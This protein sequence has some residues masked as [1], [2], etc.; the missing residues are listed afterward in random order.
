MSFEVVTEAFEP[1]ENTSTVSEQNT[2]KPEPNKNAKPGAPT[3]FA[4]MELGKWLQRSVTEA[5]YETPTPIQ[6]KTI[7]TIL[8]GLDLIGCAQTGTGKTAAF[9]LPMLERLVASLPPKEDR[10]EPRKEKPTGKFDKR[11]RRN[12]K[13]SAQRGDNRP[14]RAL[15]LA[16]TR[17]L[18]AQIG[19]SLSKYGRYTP[20]RHTVVYGGVSQYHQVKAIR[21]G[22]DTIVA[23]PGRLIDLMQQGHIKLGK[24]E[25]LVFDE[26]DQ[27]LDMGFLPDLKRIIAAVPKVRQTLMFSATMPKEIRDLAQQW[28]INPVEIQ[29]ATIAKPAEK[30]DQSVFHIASKQKPDLLAHYLSET[31]RSRTLVFSR[32]KHGADK[33][34][35]SLNNKGL[36]AAAIHGNKSQAAR[37]RVLDQFKSKKPPILVATDI[38]AR[39][40]HIDDIS[41]VINYDLPEVPETYVHRIG[42]TARAGAA[43]VAIS[44]CGGGEKGLLR[45]IERLTRQPIN[46]SPLDNGFDAPPASDTD[47]SPSKGKR[48][49]KSKGGGGGYKGGGKGGKSGG[50]QGYKKNSA[51]GTKSSGGSSSTAKRSGSKPAGAKTAGSKAK[52]SKATGSGSTAGGRPSGGYQGKKSGASASG[53]PNGKAGRRTD[54]KRPGAKPAGKPAAKRRPSAG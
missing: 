9:T 25:I 33:I 3:T 20:L 34:V 21:N 26:A 1:A 52:G 38:A 6:A 19:D 37:K 54:G 24:I 44:L 14:I 51:S 4:E 2:K 15:I 28:L 48:G 42:R 47:S 35:K 50:Y 11:G 36:K 46:V 45:Q 39:G 10:P 32:T 40:L 22:V 8:Q 30:V 18:T 49:W 17:E 13:T 41:H 16:P 31:P 23:T 27:M 7:P 53:K 5:G 43:G 29:A 12:G